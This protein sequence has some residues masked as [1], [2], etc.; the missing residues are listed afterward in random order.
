MGCGA[1]R[2]TTKRPTTRERRARMESRGCCA[3]L[4]DIL[5][6]L[7]HFDCYPVHGR[8]MM[9]TIESG[10]VVVSLRPTATLPLWPNVG[11]IIVLVDKVGR[12]VKRLTH[13][14]AEESAELR[15]W[16]WVEGDNAK[17]SEDSRVFGWVPSHRIE[18]VAILV[19]WPPWRAR[20]LVAPGRI[21]EALH[22]SPGCFDFLQRG[23]ARKSKRC[24]HATAGAATAR[25]AAATSGGGLDLSRAGDASEWVA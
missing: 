23:S 17:L 25:A 7:S 11:E 24:D 1:S 5:N 14:A 21:R 15:A 22:A 6:V 20:R 19:V 10:S 16:C 2:W 4:W 8:S 12:M 13:L 3:P 9:P 18:A